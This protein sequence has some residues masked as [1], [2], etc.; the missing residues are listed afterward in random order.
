MV[1]SLPANAGR[2]KRL[3]VWSLSREDPLEEGMAIHSSIL[4]WRI[5]WTE[6]PGGLRS[7]ESQRVGH[8]WSDLARLVLV[9]SEPPG[10]PLSLE[11]KLRVSNPLLPF[12]SGPSSLLPGPP[13]VRTQLK[14]GGQ[15]APRCVP[16]LSPQGQVGKGGRRNRTWHIWYKFQHVEIRKW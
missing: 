8:D 3:R 13:T 7:I 12:P 15:G 6:E 14:V 4:A 2:H 9:L 1:K 10:K 11:R 16:E 5:P